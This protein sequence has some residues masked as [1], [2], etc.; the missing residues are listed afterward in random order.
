MNENRII[1][2]GEVLLFINKKDG[3]ITEEYFSN[4]VEIASILQKSQHNITFLT[5]LPKNAFGCN[6]EIYLENKLSDDYKIILKDGRQGLIFLED[7]LAIIDRKY[8][9]FYFSSG[10]DYDFMDLFKDA[11]WFHF[12]IDTLTIHDDFIKT[13]TKALKI[14]KK[15]NIKVSV[16]FRSNN[17]YWRNVDSIKLLNSIAKKIDYLFIAKEQVI[18]LPFGYQEK[19]NKEVIL[20]LYKKLNA[21]VLIAFDKEKQKIYCAQNGKLTEEDTIISTKE[22]GNFE[23]YNKLIASFMDKELRK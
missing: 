3:Q 21:E 9:A 15:K 10:I 8:S 17:L 6:C 1:T 22:K 12:S 14:A 23:S 7:D 11:S 4:E 16:D 18:D 5:A 20:D 2:L 19:E 13:I